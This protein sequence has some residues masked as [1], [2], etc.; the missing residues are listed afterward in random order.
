[1]TP[2]PFFLLIVFLIT[3]KIA[4]AQIPVINGKVV[5][6]KQSPFPYVAISLYQAK[7]TTLVKG[8]LTNEQGEYTFEKIEAGV[9]LIAAS[10]IGYKRVFSQPF[11]LNSGTSVQLPKI[12]T[13]N[14]VPGEEQ[15]NTVN[16]TAK[17]PLI[18]RKSDRTILNVEN[19]TLA[20]GNNALD[21]LSKSPGVTLDNQGNISLRGRLGTAIMIDHKLT[22]LSA[23]QLVNLLKSIDGGTI[24]NIEMISNPSAKYEAAGTG[25]IININLKKNSNYGTNGTVTL[26]GGYGTYYKSNAGISLNR[27]SD[28][29]NIYGQYNFSN[30]K[31]YEDLKVRRSTGAA[32]DQTYFN[33]QAEQA[34]LK[35]NNSFKA[36][37]DY[38]LSPKSTLGLMISGY[39]N[40]SKVKDDILTRIGHDQTYADST[41][42]ASNPGYSSF[43]SQSYNLNY[44]FLADTS[45]QEFS[46]DLDCSRLHNKSLYTYQNYFFNADGS[47]RKAPYIFSNSSP[48]KINILAAKAD[49]IYPLSKRTKLEA[50]LKTSVVETDN[51]FSSSTLDAE[52]NWTNNIRQSN[53]FT[54]KEQVQAAY[55]TLHHQFDNTTL[56][57]GLRSEFTQS[58]GKSVTLQSK[59]SRSYLD[60][61]PSLSVNQKLAENHEIGLAYSRRIDRPDYQSLNPFI[62]YADLYT[63]SQG[64]PALKPQ[65]ANSLDLSYSFKQSTNLSFGYIRTRDVITTTLI[66]DTIKKTLLMYE[67]NL[68]SRSTLSMNI[69]QPLSITRWWNTS[70]DISLYYSEFKSPE[71]MGEPFKNGKTTLSL[72]TIQTFTINRSI[73]AELVANYISSQ[74][75]GTYIAK[76]IYGIDL[77]LS[78]NFLGDK[79]N[80]KLSASDIFNQRKINITSAIAGQDYQVSQKEESRIF[81]LTF[82]YNLGR[83][84]I[85]AARERSSSS[86]SEQN[87]ARSGN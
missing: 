49:Y 4:S 26:G 24:Q 51:D 79:A 78:K 1:M 32:I 45:G 39:E 48:T 68:A 74:V 11:N 14:L 31:E 46:I 81:R 76:P 66:T 56:Q 69:S 53:R 34:Y 12:Q 77:G 67:Q 73:N 17:K 61:F 18:E 38:E 86:N 63:L 8:T 29:V 55:A 82:R 75:Y 7:D 25:G 47:P 16:I 21:I 28:K 10:A 37:I 80:I 36:G 5:D 6:E 33:Q 87:R 50:G 9:Y 70:N 44:K 35:H 15:L 40:R 20:A 59:V 30:N 43:S 54:Y 27:R 64:N 58:D 83:Q 42:Q 3:A 71:L 52:G 23:E 19:S 85:K 72:N 84:T 2:S 13:L 22:Y 60:L 57:L 62:Y 41:V 65:Y